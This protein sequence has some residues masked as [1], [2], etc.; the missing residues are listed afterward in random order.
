MLK[1]ET[2]S[3]RFDSLLKV[4][5]VTSNKKMSKNK[6]PQL[7]H[8]S[9]EQK[10]CGRTAAGGL[11]GNNSPDS[12][13]NLRASPENTSKTLVGTFTLSSLHKHFGLKCFHAHKD[14]LHPFKMIFAFYF[15]RLIQR[16]VLSR[17]QHTMNHSISFFCYFSC[18]LN[19]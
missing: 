17:Q 8:N 9:A 11:S 5:F 14:A 4:V 16:K 1:A 6:S 18:R 19:T 12:T 13:S 7:L 3:K 2:H 15:S 10:M